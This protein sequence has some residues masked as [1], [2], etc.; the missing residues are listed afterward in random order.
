MNSGFR[1]SMGLRVLVFGSSGFLG[2]RVLAYWSKESL[3]C[4]RRLPRDSNPLIESPSLR[5]LLM[6]MGAF[7]VRGFTV[8][9]SS[10]PL[11]DSRS[12]DSWP[13]NRTQQP[14]GAHEGNEPEHG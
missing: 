7:L 10:L 14:N 9:G 5:I 13:R 1:V 6:S 3:D 11:A 8:F 12:V 4:R 2:F